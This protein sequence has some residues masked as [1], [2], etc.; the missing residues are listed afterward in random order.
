LDELVIGEEAGGEKDLLD[1][2]DPGFQ[3][4][5]SGNFRFSKQSYSR[6]S[7]LNQI[8]KMPSFDLFGNP[9]IQEGI[10]D[11]GPV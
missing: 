4:P 3:D 5:K 10:V 1:F 7:S 8:K 9:R 6:I 11:L 2:I